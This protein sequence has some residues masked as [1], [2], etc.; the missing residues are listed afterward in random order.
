MASGLRSLET[1]STA[2]SRTCASYLGV[3]PVAVMLAVG[4]I[5][6]LDFLL[7]E[8]ERSL[9]MQLNAGL[10]RIAADPLVGCLML[11]EIWDIPDAAKGLLIA[12]HEDATQ[13]ELFPP[14][15]LPMLLQG[16]QD[17]A[18]VLNGLDADMAA[19]GI[20]PRKISSI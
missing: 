18:L 9:T 3:P 1:M 7:P 12:L 2:L 8:P 10:E 11:P 5:Q 19:N 15:R 17:A 13:Q 6:T 4:R 14:R 20:D 16:L